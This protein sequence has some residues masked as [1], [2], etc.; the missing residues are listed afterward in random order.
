MAAIM[1]FANIPALSDPRLVIHRK[2]GEYNLFYICAKFCS[3]DNMFERNFDKLKTNSAHQAM[4]RV[5]HHL[6]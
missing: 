5:K 1:N 6:K 4:Y 3:F 2:S